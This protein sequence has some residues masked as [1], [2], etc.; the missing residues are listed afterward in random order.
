[1]IRV[2]PLTPW[3]D[4]RG[5]QIER[6]YIDNGTIAMEVISLGGIIRS[7]WVPNKDDERG[8]VVLGCDTA[9]DYL[10]QQAHLGAIA[11]RYANL[12]LIHI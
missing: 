11:G 10:N 4:P 9:E 5:G 2:R 1:M 7:L 3:Q 12:S 8:N 6:I